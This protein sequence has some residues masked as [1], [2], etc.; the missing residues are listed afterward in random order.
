MGLRWVSLCLV[1]Y[2]TLCSMSWMFSG[3]YFMSHCTIN[4]WHYMMCYLSNIHILLYNVP[5]VSAESIIWVCAVFSSSLSAVQF[6][7][8]VSEHSLNGFGSY[9]SDSVVYNERII[10]YW[11]WIKL[12]ITFN[13]VGN[14][15]R[16][17]NWC[18]LNTSQ[19]NQYDIQES[20][21]KGFTWYLG[22][23]LRKYCSSNPPNKKCCVWKMWICPNASVIPIENCKLPQRCCMHSEVMSFVCN[24]ISCE[25]SVLKIG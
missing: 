11:F 5:G 24:A 6:S 15:F 20:N 12:Q 2:N 25:S 17:I 1:L 22:T 7:D 9:N 14:V 21:S 16:F 10:A 13:Y 8:F 3:F 18:L 23:E 19:V 4:I